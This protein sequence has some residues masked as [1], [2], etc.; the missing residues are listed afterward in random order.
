MD[1]RK[2]QSVIF[3]C[4]ANNKKHFL[5]L[6]VNEHRGLFWQNSTGSVDDG[7]EYLDAAQRE[8]IEETKLSVENIELIS[9][10]GIG[11]TFKD[12]WGFNAHEKT[13]FIKCKRHWEVVLDPSEHVEFKWVPEQDFSRDLLKYSSNSESVLKCMEVL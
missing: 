6:K 5:L 2:V 11:F 4:D 9:E 12:R 3:Y 7:E 13:F 8:A 10:A 1:K